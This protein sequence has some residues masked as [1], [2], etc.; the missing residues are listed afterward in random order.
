[1][2]ANSMVQSNSQ[3]QAAAFDQTSLLL[4][5]CSRLFSLRKPFRRVTN[6]RSIK[7]ARGGVRA[8]RLHVHATAYSLSEPEPYVV[9]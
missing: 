8:S 4:R 9:C 5:P 3:G 6:I 7:L 2:S 1:M